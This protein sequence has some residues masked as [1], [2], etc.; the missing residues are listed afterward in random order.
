MSLVREQS[1]STKLLA[2]LIVLSVAANM[3]G[4]NGA[5]LVAVFLAEYILRI[6]HTQCPSVFLVPHFSSPSPHPPTEITPCFFPFAANASSLGATAEFQLVEVAVA[7]TGA[8]SDA[9][10]KPEFCF[11]VWDRDGNMVRDQAKLRRA[12]KL[13]ANDPKIRKL[14]KVS[15]PAAPVRH[16]SLCSRPSPRLV[17]QIPIALCLVSSQ[18]PFYAPLTLLPPDPSSSRQN[19]PLGFGHHDCSL[20]GLVASD[21]YQPRHCTPCQSS[22]EAGCRHQAPAQIRQDS[23]SNCQTPNGPAESPLKVG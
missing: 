16:L 7:G 15:K 13:F 12:A 20:Q 10:T 11:A 19:L 8:D 17:S 1:M 6:P 9:A 21:L 18:F 23:S 3:A 4:V 14:C 22:T 5:C 2:L